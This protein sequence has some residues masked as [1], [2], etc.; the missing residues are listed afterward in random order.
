MS[1]LTIAAIA[2][3]VIVIAVV[4]FFAHVLS[5]DGS[6]LVSIGVYF[7]ARLLGGPLSA[8]TTV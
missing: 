8:R 4:L 7:I 5:F 3:I 1:G 6:L 2:A